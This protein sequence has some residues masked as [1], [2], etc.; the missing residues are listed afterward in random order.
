MIVACFISEGMVIFN[1]QDCSKK[2]AFVICQ[3]SQCNLAQE[4]NHNC[5]KLLVVVCS[6]VIFPNYKL[7]HWMNTDSSGL[8]FD[9]HGHPTK[10]LVWTDIWSK[11]V[12]FGGF[13]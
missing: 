9:S 3:S 5:C 11:D 8:F 12:A 7:D 6:V 13:D 2:A 4:L 10:C 1:N